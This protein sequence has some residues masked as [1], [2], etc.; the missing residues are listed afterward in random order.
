MRVALVVE[1]RRALGY[2]RLF[3][4]ARSPLRA[5]WSKAP[6]S[7]PSLYLPGAFVCVAARRRAFLRQTRSVGV[8]DKTHTA[9]FCLAT[10]HQPLF[11]GVSVPADCKEKRKLATAPGRK[12]QVSWLTVTTSRVGRTPTGWGDG[13]GSKRQRG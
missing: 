9:V 10:D 13:N 7:P 8:A 11:A 5:L 1:G 3:Q 6:F 12:S 4:T 2:L